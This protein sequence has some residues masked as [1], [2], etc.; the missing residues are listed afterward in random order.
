MSKRNLATQS[1][2]FPGSP[3]QTRQRRLDEVLALSQ[4]GDRQTGRCVW[5]ELDLQQFIQ[6]RDSADGVMTPLPPPP[7][8]LADVFNFPVSQRASRLR[9]P[10]T[11]GR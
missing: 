7:R 9:S 1:I 8:R 5:E 2:H 4:R 11:Y 6:A 10:A 3:A